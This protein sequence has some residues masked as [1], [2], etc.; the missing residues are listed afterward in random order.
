MADG[1][2]TYRA[3][4]VAKELGVDVE[5]VNGLVNNGHIDGF[6]S[7]G[8]SGQP[9]TSVYQDQLPLLRERMSKMTK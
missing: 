1:R 9:S 3:A 2:P 5:L 8:T 4:Y 6:R 7:T